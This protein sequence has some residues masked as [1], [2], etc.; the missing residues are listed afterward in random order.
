MAILN[1][2]VFQLRQAH[3]KAPSDLRQH[4]S[5]YSGLIDIEFAIRR[6]N[7]KIYLYVI[8]EIHAGNP[9]DSRQC[10]GEDGVREKWVGLDLIKFN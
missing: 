4:P 8:W 1:L 10:V 3:A 5:T 7:N 6:S 9:S 2:Q